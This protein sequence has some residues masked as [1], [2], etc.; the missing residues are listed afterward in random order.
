[1]SRLN[2]GLPISRSRMISKDLSQSSSHVVTGII[3]L[4]AW[5]GMVANFNLYDWIDSG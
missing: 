3:F 4:C 1:M 5:R 2:V